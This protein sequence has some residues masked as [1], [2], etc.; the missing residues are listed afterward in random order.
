MSL[1]NSAMPPG[2]SLTVT[3]I[4]NNLPSAAKPLSK[5]RP[6]I[7]VS[8]LPPV[9]MH[10]ILPEQEISRF[11]FFKYVFSTYFLPIYSSNFPDNT[12]A[13]AAAAEPSTTH[14]SDSINLKMATANVSSDTVIYNQKSYK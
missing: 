4:F 8:M 1:V 3:S 11:K 6:S 7:V 14:F 13:T 2:L 5:Q 12:A 9:N 10:T